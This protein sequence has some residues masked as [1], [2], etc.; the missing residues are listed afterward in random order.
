MHLFIDI[1]G[2]NTRL[3]TSADAKS[4]AK[5]VIIPTEQDFDRALENIAKEIKKLTSGNI[6][7]A[8]VGLPGVMDKSA[9]SLIM[10]PNLPE[11]VNKPIVEEVNK[12]TGSS[13]KFVN[14][15]DLAGLGEAWYGAGKDYNIVTYFTISTGVG[16]SRI[17]NKKIDELTYGFEPG[18]QIIDAG[19]TLCPNC[20]SPSS[21]ED[22]IGGANVAKR[23]N[24]HPKEIKDEQA[25]DTMALWLSYGLNNVIAL[26]SPEVIVLGGPMMRDIPIDKVRKYTAELAVFVPQIPDIKAA[27]HEDEKAFY[28]AL[29]LLAGDNN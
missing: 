26:W 17:V 10:A 24:C 27:V 14:D 4:F 22:L 19:G 13:T 2:T 9:G 7:S 18:F 21:L 5:P 11:W 8:I 25:W 3:T 29:A 23:F 28:G 6:T 1:G 16:G 15:S 12:I 20:H